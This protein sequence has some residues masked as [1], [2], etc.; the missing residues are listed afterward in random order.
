MKRENALLSRRAV[1]TALG[2]AAALMALGSFLDFPISQALYNES[3]L[4]GI[5]LAAFGEYPAVLGFAAAGAM[6]IAGH[7]REKKLT[8]ILQCVGGAVLAALGTLMASF[9]PSIYLTWPKPV[10]AVI[11]VACGIAVMA[12]VFRL[13]RNAGR[14]ELIRV[15]AALFFVIFAEIVLINIVKIPWGRARMRLVANDPRA[16][17]MPWWQTGSSLK[18]TLVAA[19]VAGEEFK[20]FPS[21]HT[22]NAAALILILG[23]LPRLVNRL[24]DKK[25]LLLCIGFAWTAL[26]AFSRIIMGAHYLTDTV[27]GFVVSLLVMSLVCGLVFRKEKSAP[28]KALIND[29]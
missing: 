4:F 5:A 19:G 21:G 3:S 7:S 11:G 23:L 1:L 13:A 17:F 9:M 15:G 16:Y 8:G 2:T 29:T 10:V 22:G 24:A 25:G 26:V 6:L 12:L 28:R 27:V 20:S 18:D 14:E